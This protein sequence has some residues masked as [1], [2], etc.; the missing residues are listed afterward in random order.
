MLERLLSICKSRYKFILAHILAI[1]L[2]HVQTCLVSKLDSL[3]SGTLGHVCLWFLISSL[4]SRSC[5]MFALAASN[6]I[7]LKRIIQH[8]SRDLK[9][10]NRWHLQVYLSGSRDFVFATSW[11]YWCA[12]KYSD[13]ITTSNV[14]YIINTVGPIGFWHGWPVSSL[15]GSS[16]GGLSYQWCLDS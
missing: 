2:G 16:M 8:T 13:R 12:M 1:L 9:V 15:T 3:I 14:A 7:E 6:L 5:S 10:R 11:W 4:T